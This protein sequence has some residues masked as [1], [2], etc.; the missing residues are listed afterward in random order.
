MA[1]F[2]LVLLPFSLQSYG[3][4]EYKSAS[5]IVLLVIGFC[6]FFVFAAWEKYGTSKHFYPV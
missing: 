6:M 5:F 4:A 3:R 1:A 2:L